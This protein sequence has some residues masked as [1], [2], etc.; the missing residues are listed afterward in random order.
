MH[1]LW[2][3]VESQE[4]VC[5]SLE[6]CECELGLHRPAAIGA[7]PPATQGSFDTRLKLPADHPYARVSG[8]NDPT[9]FPQI[10][11]RSGALLSATG[12]S[13]A[14]PV[15]HIVEERTWLMSWLPSWRRPSGPADEERQRLEGWVRLRIHLAA[16][17]PMIAIIGA[18]ARLTDAGMTV[19]DAT[20]TALRII[21][22]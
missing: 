20:E 10:H 15:C 19:E 12:L 7:R 3:L 11:R 18:V 9:E 13:F 22:E 1:A 8:L 4:L 6:Q 21:R 14:R 5:R 16:S 2:R 17:D